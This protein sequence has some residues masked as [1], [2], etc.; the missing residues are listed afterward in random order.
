MDSSPQKHVE[1]V[2]E[3]MACPAEGCYSLHLT[4]YVAKSLAE[5]LQKNGT[6]EIQM[7]GTCQDLVEHQRNRPEKLSALMRTECMYQLATLVY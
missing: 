1:D 6:M 4:L 7:A 2:A 5:N 3:C